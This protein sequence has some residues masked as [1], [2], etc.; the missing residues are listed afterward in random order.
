MT[1]EVELASLGEP[2]IA[3]HPPSLFCT[4]F[5]QPTAFCT[6]ASCP[7][8]AASACT[9]APVWL[10]SRIV[11]VSQ[12]WCGSARKAVNA[13]SAHCCPASH[14]TPEAAG[15]TPT[16]CCASRASDCRQTP[17][18]CGSLVPYSPSG[19]FGD[20][21]GDGEPAYAA[22]AAAPSRAAVASAGAARRARTASRCVVGAMVA[23]GSV[24]LSGRF[25]AH[26]GPTQRRTWWR[27]PWFVPRRVLRLERSRELGGGS[28]PDFHRLPPIGH[29]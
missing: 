26:T 4:D 22:G 29:E 24:C 11:L 20:A 5:S 3:L 27:E 16:V 18:Y 10:V 19:S 28:A 1:T 25:A 21:D 7:P 9:A 13:P 14:A 15:R 8:S 12:P 2:G 23:I 17:S 6:A